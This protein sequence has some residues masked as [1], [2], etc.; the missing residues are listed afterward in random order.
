MRCKSHLVQPGCGEVCA[1]TVLG[2]QKLG[3]AR[4]KQEVTLTRE[5]GNE[6]AKVTRAARSVHKAETQEIGR[7]AQGTA[8]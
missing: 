1:F 6:Q 2:W 8:D 4:E 7:R 5:E 3:T